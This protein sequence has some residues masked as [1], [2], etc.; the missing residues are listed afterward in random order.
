[1]LRL[2]SEQRPAV[3]R[4]KNAWRKFWGYDSLGPAVESDVAASLAP[5]L[6][7]TDESSAT[8][9]PRY[10][11]ADFL[12]RAWEIIDEARAE[13]DSS[14]FGLV[15]PWG[16]GKTSMLDWLRAKATE[17]PA[18]TDATPW[19]VLT[20]NPWDY[21]D[22]GTL[23]L[24]F[25]ASLQ[26]TFGSSR[27]DDVRKF[28]S[29]LG[30]AVAP[31]T[32]VASA[33]GV[34][35]ASKVV[36]G[37]AKL[38]GGNRSAEAA[39]RKLIKTLQREKTPVL[40]VIDDLDRIS[41]DELLLTLKLVRQLGRLPYVHYLLSYDE[42]TILDVLT[43]TNL[44]GDG[45]LGRARNYMEKVVQI[46]FDVP[47][48]RPSDIVELTNDALRAL[49]ADTGHAIDD[50][51]RPRFQDAYERFIST[52]LTTPRA[53][54]RYF[55]QARILSPRFAG[56]VDLVD[57]LILTWIRTFE[58]GV[59][60]VLQNRRNVLI[61]SSSDSMGLVSQQDHRSPDTVRDYWE[62]VFI[63]AG[64]E[65]SD[66]HSVVAAVASLFPR[67]A[68][69]SGMPSGGGS[70][71]GPHIAS[72][73]YFD[74]YFTAG[75]PDGDLR[76]SVA[77]QAIQD[78]ERGLGPTSEAAAQCVASLRNSPAR[79]APKIAAAAG[80]A[81]ITSPATFGWLA[82]IVSQDFD[83]VDTLDWTLGIRREIARRL[84]ELPQDDVEV[85]LR[86]MSGRRRGA[87]VAI[88]AHWATEA[89]ADGSTP[90][91]LT[92]GARRAVTDAIRGL[93]TAEG[94]TV[95]NMRWR[96]REAL[97]GWP[98]M[99]PEGF[100]SWIREQIR[101]HGELETLSWFV[102][103][104]VSFEGGVEHTRVE[105]F[106]TVEAQR[107]F[108]FAAIAKQYANELPD[109]YMKMSD[110]PENRRTAALGAIAEILAKP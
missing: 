84:R 104:S 87:V 21:P 41:A 44:I 107:F 98:E 65:R 109:S 64:T 80:D 35:D 54:R 46:R 71:L 26:S 85:V 57:F 19:S 7:L 70:H 32:S 53:L 20:F 43:R 34:F 14:V 81:K 36:E 102:R 23:Q 60:A 11:R 82:D 42:S 91:E 103:L 92:P 93:L 86:A 5:K 68:H 77:R 33:W 4:A 16:S 90:L 39:R 69:T 22:A 8:I 61:G 79:T 49:E 18:S 72:G 110:T 13:E 96:V 73:D 101:T 17:E 51:A 10:G 89:A 24:G 6:W 76:D 95:M 27:F 50:L 9:A 48:L 108:D 66:A 99:D 58:P 30:V 15:G 37:S 62:Q 59:Y 40:I 38:L 67:L 94:A 106:Q 63:D 31:I 3:R 29:D 12:L 105:G 1:M 100:E 47:Q 88:S 56:E 2:M 52:R 75:V 28:I 55:A 74:R 83:R 25:F 78:Y 97:T 45:E